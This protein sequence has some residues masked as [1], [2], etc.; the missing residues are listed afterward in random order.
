MVGG[1]GRLQT[2]AHF[3]AYDRVKASDDGASSEALWGL[4]DVVLAT[5]SLSFRSLAEQR[6]LLH[7]QMGHLDLYAQL[8]D[9]AAAF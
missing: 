6:T 4:C 9:N 3:Y 1:K 2:R 7:K 8:I 5:A